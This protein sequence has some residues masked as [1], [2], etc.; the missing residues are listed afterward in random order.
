MPEQAG[1]DFAGSSSQQPA[2]QPSTSISGGISP[3]YAGVGQP[4]F[5]YGGYPGGG[6]IG[7][8]YVA[9]G[10]GGPGLGSGWGGPAFAGGCGGGPC[11]GGL[12]APAPLA[13]APLPGAIGYVPGGFGAV[14][15]G[16]TW[17]YPVNGPPLPPVQNCQLGYCPKPNQS[18]NTR[19]Y[20]YAISDVHTRQFT[21]VRCTGNSGSA[22][23]NYGCPVPVPVAPVVAGCGP[24]PCRLPPQGPI[25][26][27]PNARVAKKNTTQK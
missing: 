10:W 23:F 21:P 3:A 6:G 20:T 2:G 18:V 14:G 19:W 15:C 16:P 24:G 5:G 26:A 1:T 11:V 7:V 4:G 12:G 25:V 8:P 17:S 13:G 27:G 9:S 22:P